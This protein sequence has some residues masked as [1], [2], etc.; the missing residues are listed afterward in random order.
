M[1]AKTFNLILQ[2]AE[3][4]TPTVRHLAFTREDGAAMSY[5]PGQFINIHI[6]GNDKSLHRSYSVATLNGGQQ[7]LEIACSYVTGGIATHLLSALKPGDAV[8]A[9]GPYGRLVLKEETPKRYLLISTGTGITPYR[10]MLGQLQTRL[11]QKR[12]EKIIFLQGVRT[13]EELFYQTD[14]LNA[15]RTHPAMEFHACYSR[16]FPADPAFYEKRGRV[17]ATLETLTLDPATDIIYLCGN[18][19]MIDEAFAYLKGLGFNPTSIR[20]EKYISTN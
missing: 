6:V 1:Q 13:R 7:T 19:N 5:I 10:A 11:D 16:E 3:L 9:S 4:L 14:F 2:S 12:I 8:T 20:R 18:P 15:A 17:L